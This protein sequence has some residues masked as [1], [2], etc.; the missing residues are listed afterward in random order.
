MQAWEDEY[1]EYVTARLPALRRLGY[2]LSG[3]EDSADDLVQQTITT[4][5]VHWR[6]VSAV[7]HLDQ[8]VR[9]MLVRA[10]L[11]EKRRPWSRVRLVEVPDR[12]AGGPPDVESRLVLRA[13]LGQ[14]PPRQRAV[15]VL[16]FLCDLSVPEVAAALQCST[17]TVKSQT[18]HG[19]AT[20]RRLLGTQTLAALGNGK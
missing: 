11:D 20:L 18:S 10:V 6:R 8:Y 5:Y 7:T 16:R 17:G 3:S 1:V 14:V 15:L 9:S 13:A 4:L 12:P 2:L 19:L